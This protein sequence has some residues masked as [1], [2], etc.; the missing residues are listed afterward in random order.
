MTEIEQ[1]GERRRLVFTNIANGV[2]L[3]DVMAAFKMSELEVTNDLQFVLRK[4]KEYRYAMTVNGGSKSSPLV[5]PMIAADTYADVLAFGKSMLVTL[6]KLGNQTL[7]SELFLYKPIKSQKIDHPSSMQEVN[8]R[9][10]P[11]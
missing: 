3:P 11:A 4:I 9:M 7:G 1:K 6:S 10:S 2:P 5:A 8:H